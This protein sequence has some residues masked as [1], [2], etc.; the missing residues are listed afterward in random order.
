MQVG[1]EVLE[2]NHAREAAGM[3]YGLEFP[4]SAETL[5]RMGA[6][7]LTRA[8]HAAGTLSPDNRVTKVTSNRDFVGGGACSKLN[9]DVEYEHPSEH[10]HTKLFAKIPLPL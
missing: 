4:W 6:P 1:M 9:F 5:D 7:W 3:I 10:L 2:E 8:F